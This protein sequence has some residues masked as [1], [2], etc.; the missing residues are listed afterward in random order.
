VPNQ[1]T[2][3]PS[4]VCFLSDLHLPDTQLTS[5]DSGHSDQQ[6]AK[7]DLGEED[8]LDESA[9]L[10][11]PEVSLSNARSLVLITSD[12]KTIIDNVRSHINLSRWRVFTDVFSGAQKHSC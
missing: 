8:G 7:S 9:L 1:G 4:S 5:T 6:D 2:N 10:F 3:S 12:E 11:L